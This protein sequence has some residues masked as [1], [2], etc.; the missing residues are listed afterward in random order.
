MI[1]IKELGDV[2]ATESDA[3]MAIEVERPA[4][5]NST[6]VF[7]RIFQQQIEASST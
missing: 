6:E 7:K 1:R 4:I 3:S 2:Y 5:F